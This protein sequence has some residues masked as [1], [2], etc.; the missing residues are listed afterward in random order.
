M[1]SIN[2]F[3][4]LDLFKITE[5]NNDDD[6]IIE[7]NDE[8][9]YEMMGGAEGDDDVVYFHNNN[10]GG[11]RF[12]G[13]GDG[14]GRLNRR[15]GGEVKMADVGFFNV[16]QMRR[17]DNVIQDMLSGRVMISLYKT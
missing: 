12:G 6:V 4:D 5:D 16:K 2:E 10:G 9:S 13:Y 11:G 8:D 7:K 14:G 3:G 15:K 1:L 17:Y